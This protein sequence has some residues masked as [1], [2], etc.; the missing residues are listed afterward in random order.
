[1]G[2]STE[3]FKLYVFSVAFVFFSVCHAHEQSMVLIP[4]G[5]YV[6]FFITKKKDPKKSN[7][8]PVSVKSFLIDKYPVTQKEFLAFL[9]KNPQWQKS[10]V[11]NIFVDSHYLENW[12]GDTKPP[13]NQ[14]QAP[15]VF[16][17][18]FAANA[19][20]KSLNKK[21]PSVDQWEYVADDHGHG[22]KEAKDKILDWYSKPNPTK[23]PSVGKEKPNG[24]GV[25]NL[26]GLVWEWTLDFNSAIIGDESRA[27]GT[28]DNSLF[29]GSGALG[30]IDPADYARFMRYSFRSSLKANYT[31]GNLG[32]RCAKDL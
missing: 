22:P 14:L 26:Y 8:Q 31:T 18:W 10:E 30:S 16:V 25:Y 12:S 29:C 9:K 32:F 27:S 21:L 24:Y 23:L 6:P 19:Y 2:L 13:A 17:S 28:T 15:V 7:D 5:S 20:C 3:L 1:M 4:S 11:K